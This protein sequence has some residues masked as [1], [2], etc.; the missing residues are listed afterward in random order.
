MKGFSMWEWPEWLR[1]PEMDLRDVHVYAGLIIATGGGVFISV[2][3][4]LVALGLFLACLGI[5]LPNRR[6][7]E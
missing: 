3:W 4:T 7:P 2:A 5:F 6:R 1:W